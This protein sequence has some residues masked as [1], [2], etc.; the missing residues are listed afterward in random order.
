MH[1]IRP[2]Y[3]FTFLIFT[4]FVVFSVLSETPFNFA[5]IF[6]VFVIVPLLDLAI[7]VRSLNVDIETEKQW[8]KL[9]VWAPAIYLYCISHFAV[10]YLALANLKNHTSFEVLV[11]GISVGL[12]TG[13]IGI[14]VAHELCHK[15]EKLNRVLADLLL[16]SVAYTHFA[17]EHVRGHHFAVATLNDPASARRGESAYL[18]LPRTIV[19]SFLNACRLEIKAVLKGLVMTLAFLLLSFFVA[20][21]IGVVFFLIQ[22]IVAIVLLELVNYVEHYGLV[23][24]QLANGRYEV[25]NPQHSWNSSHLFSNLLL[26]NLQ[27]HSDHHAAAHLPYTVL[28]HHE[29]APQL[30][31]GYPFMILLALVPPAWFRVMHKNLDSRQS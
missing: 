11:I 9:S 28:K 21:V 3:F 13:G 8:K 23:R 12:Y 15:R 19:G 30:V 10:L 2:Y 26:F 5:A 31:S 17:I 14:T 4:F 20:G 29:G 25:V 6:F 7:G 16:S 18:F 22:S 1:M 27:K 24:R